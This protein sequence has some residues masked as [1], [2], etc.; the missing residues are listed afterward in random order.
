M[1][2]SYSP[3]EFRVNAKKDNG[4]ERAEL[5]GRTQRDCGLGVGRDGMWE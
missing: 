1:G 4:V 5:R 2:G 3:K